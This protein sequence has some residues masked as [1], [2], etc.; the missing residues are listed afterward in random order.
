MEKERLKKIDEVLEA[1]GI[2][3]AT[4]NLYISEKYKSLIIKEWVFSDMQDT[5]HSLVGDEGWKDEWES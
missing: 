5:L 3:W 1:N 2:E 4:L